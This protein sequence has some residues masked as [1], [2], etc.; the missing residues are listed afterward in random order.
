VYDYVLEGRRFEQGGE[1]RAVVTGQGYAPGDPRRGLGGFTFDHDAADAVDP[2]RLRDPDA[3]GTIHVEHD[4]RGLRSDLRGGYTIDATAHPTAKAGDFVVS[5]ERF[6]GG[7][8]TVE[9][10]SKGDIDHE[11][12]KSALE[13][14]SLKSKWNA[15]GAGRADVTVQNG[16]IPPSVGTLT[17]TECWGTTFKQVYYTDSAGIAETSGDLSACP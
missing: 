14:L 13:D 17:M 1:F 16:D 9:I 2:A 5:L 12:S 8:G 6:D 3:S 10:V 15:A 4:L 11:A 7:G